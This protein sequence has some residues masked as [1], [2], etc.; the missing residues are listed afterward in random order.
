MKTKRIITTILVCFLVIMVSAACEL[1]DGPPARDNQNDDGA[2]TDYKVSMKFDPG[3]D[4]VGFS[5]EITG[6]FAS[7]E[8]GNPVYT[9]T[10]GTAETSDPDEP[11]NTTIT[12]DSTEAL[13][14]DLEYG[15]AY[16]FWLTCTDEDFDEIVFMKF[17]TA[18]PEAEG[19]LDKDFDSDGKF[20]ITDL[21][22]ATEAYD[23]IADAD[24]NVY[25]SGSSNVVLQMNIKFSPVGVYDSNFYSAQSGATFDAA[26]ALSGNNL[27]TFLKKDTSNELGYFKG[28]DAYTTVPMFYYAA[29]TAVGTDDN[30][31][32]VAG[33]NGASRYSVMSFDSAVSDTGKTEYSCNGTEYFTTEA[34]GNVT[35]LY[36]RNDYVYSVGVLINPDDFTEQIHA[37]V[38]DADEIGSVIHTLI[39][40]SDWSPDQFRT[41][42]TL[43]STTMVNVPGAKIASDHDNNVYV[44]GVGIISK[45]CEN[46]DVFDMDSSWPE[47]DT[48][49]TGSIYLSDDFTPADIIVQENGKIVLFGN[50]WQDTSA[51]DVFLDKGVI[52]RYNPDGSPDKTFGTE[53]II[54]FSGT[55]I[56]GGDIKPDGRIIFAAM[57]SNGGAVY[58]LR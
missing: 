30:L 8:L 22:T 5:Y 31:V 9:L 43:G 44:T 27:Y 7:D 13:I 1:F 37:V 50:L 42:T 2:E 58:Q 39:F 52:L 36:Y 33:Q 54:E 51:P 6:D 17:G 14:E 38:L 29:D 34:T 32:I 25:V 53:G 18:M 11:Y 21:Y 56:V 46:G 4:Y 55:K 28:E 41:R 49:S 15:D 47:A 24:N 45:F 40:N 35:G 10:Y 23:V 20:S 16:N 57:D 19:I 48:N 12:L 3:V 26:C